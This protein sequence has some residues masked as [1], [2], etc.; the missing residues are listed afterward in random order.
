MVRAEFSQS[1]GL[2]LMKRSIKTTD[3]VDDMETIDDLKQ[4]TKRL[5]SIINRT[6]LID[7]KL[8]SYE[9]SNPKK[10]VNRS[11]RLS[12][13]S[14]RTEIPQSPFTSSLVIDQNPKQQ[15]NEI[16]SELLLSEMRAI[17]SEL[18]LIIT[19]QDEM[20]REISKIKAK[21]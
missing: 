18:A 17:R 8:T 9:I 6:S 15:K 4:I 10:T 13:V 7:E 16:T 11:T 12:P 1:V 2:E 14:N 20:A 5:E 19:K 21:I 3:K